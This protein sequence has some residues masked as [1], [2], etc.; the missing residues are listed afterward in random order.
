M[1]AEIRSN[2]QVYC[3]VSIERLN[4]LINISD[5]AVDVDFNETDEIKSKKIEDFELQT[6]YSCK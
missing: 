2:E 6:Y 3:V 5:V 1:A 4:I